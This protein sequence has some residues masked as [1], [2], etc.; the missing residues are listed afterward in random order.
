MTRNLVTTLLLLSTL[1]VG[2]YTQNRYEEERA[3]AWCALYD[4]CGYLSYI[5]AEDYD[6]CVEV[7]L[8]ASYECE[9]YDRAAAK[10]CVLGIDALTCEEHEEGFYPQACSDVCDSTV[11]TES[12]E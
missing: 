11:M 10:E 2:C 1:S 9:G 8:T 5:G 3:A 7:Q 6:E 4:E 12:D